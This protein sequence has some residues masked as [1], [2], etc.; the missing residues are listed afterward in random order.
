MLPFQRLGRG[1]ARTAKERQFAL[2]ST[3]KSSR[4]ARWKP[5]CS[6]ETLELRILLAAGALDTTFGSGGKVTTIGPG[7]MMAMSL[8]SDGKIAAV[9]LPGTLGGDGVG[10]CYTANGNLNT[11]FDGDGHLTT[12]FGGQ[13]QAYD[14]ALQSDGKIVV[15]GT[16]ST[17]PNATDFHLALAR[18]NT[19][20][21]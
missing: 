11:A 17:G 7:T 5:A 6:I 20:G 18:Y 21:M 14:V 9:G 15:A 1:R 8:G 13:D 4:R 12:D 3:V 16:Y 19:N 2:R 10:V